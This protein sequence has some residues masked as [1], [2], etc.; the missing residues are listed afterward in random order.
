MIKKSP[1]ANHLPN[2]R[3]REKKIS[4]IDE[5]LPI[6]YLFYYLLFY[7]VSFLCATLQKI[8]FTHPLRLYENPLLPFQW[9]SGLVLEIS[10][11]TFFGKDF[12]TRGRHFSHRGKLDRNHGKLANGQRTDSRGHQ[13]QCGFQSLDSFLSRRHDVFA[14]VS[15]LVQ[16]LMV[17]SYY[18]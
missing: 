11:S 14:S 15:R 1:N 10:L 17:I 16:W 7:L 13:K 8:D 5:W 9:L 2:T 6:R 4:L 3:L 18:F 12:A